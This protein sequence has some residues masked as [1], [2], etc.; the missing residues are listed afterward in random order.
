MSEDLRAV[1]TRILVEDLE[2]DN[3]TLTE[4][5]TIASMDLD[6][7]AIAELVI[8]IKEETGADLGSEEA[9]IGDLTVPAL[10]GMVAAALGSEQPA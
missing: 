4:A 1:L 9:S 3:S 6:S 7:L 2:A 10:A 8:R 5:S